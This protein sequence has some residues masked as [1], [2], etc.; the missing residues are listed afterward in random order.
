MRQRVTSTA[1]A[2]LVA[3]LAAA[4]L[5]LA[6]AASWAGDGGNGGSGSTRGGSGD[7]STISAT[8]DSHVVVHGDSPGDGAPLVSSDASYAPPPC[9]Y[10]PRFT[11]EQYLV[12][13]RQSLV[14]WDT[15]KSYVKKQLDTLEGEH[16]NIGK[17][18]LWWQLDYN[19]SMPAF[20]ALDDC[21]YQDDT[22]WVPTGDPTPPP[23]A[24]TPEELSR[25]AYSATRLPA[26]P[27]TLSPSP[28]KQVVN[29][30]TYVSFAAPLRRVWVTASLHELGVDIAATTVATPVSLRVD[31]GTADAS[32]GSCTYPL[33]AAGGGYRVDSRHAGCNI[34]YRRS[35]G[36]GSYPLT[37]RITWKVTWTASRD[38]DGP[39]ERPALPDGL[40][41]YRRAV[42]V[43]EIQTVVR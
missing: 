31:A 15:G 27:V 29:L 1:R 8:A 24:L 12:Y 10:E 19:T 43:R 35:T 38:P 18:G 5:L 22:I 3:G 34:T 13:Y 20:T 2:G 32:P 14:G 37:A 28:A 11:P 23:G 42:A 33:T 9:W 6:P 7:G 25:I 41:T 40:S 16:Y 26:P 21:P 4:A 39:A 36:G 30:P 17:K